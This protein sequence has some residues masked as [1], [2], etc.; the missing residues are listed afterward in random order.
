MARGA[1]G[2]GLH[3]PDGGLAMAAEPA[4]ATV[5]DRYAAG[6]L[7]QMMGFHKLSKAGGQAKTDSIGQLVST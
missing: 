1:G 7:N 6:A 2:Q 5:L 3:A 4:F